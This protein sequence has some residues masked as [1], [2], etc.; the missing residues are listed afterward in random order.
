MHR[1]NMVWPFTLRS[2]NVVA[3]TVCASMPEGILI[4][5]K[6]RLVASHRSNNFLPTL[7]VYGKELIKAKA[8]RLVEG[9]ALGSPLGGQSPKK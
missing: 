8:P 3:L 4:I 9:A 1:T 2:E 5:F 6:V 7:T